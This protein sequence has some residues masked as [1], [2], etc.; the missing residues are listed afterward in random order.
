MAYIDF[1][2][3]SPVA[4]DGVAPLTDAAATQT[5]AQ[6]AVEFSALEWRVISLAH[7]D[8]L[9][10]LEPLPQRSWLGRLLLGPLPP[11]RGLAN[12]R[13]EALRRLAVE[14][15]CR[16]WLVR[17]SAIAAARVAGFTKAQIDRVFDVVGP[18]PTLAQRNFA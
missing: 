11:A 9:E 14:A 3:T 18:A 13:L 2:Q 15:R 8:G 6:T 1:S 7:H 17:P 4:L 5:V 10:T 12:E 16:G